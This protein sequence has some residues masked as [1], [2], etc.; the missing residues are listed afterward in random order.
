MPAGERIGGDVGFLFVGS[1]LG[2][3]FALVISLLWRGTGVLVGVGRTVIFMGGP[4]IGGGLLSGYTGW[5]L[6]TCGR[7]LGGLGD[8][9]VAGVVR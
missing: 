7:N 3:G 5:Y 6:A 1:L 9:P 8:A 4:Y 2:F